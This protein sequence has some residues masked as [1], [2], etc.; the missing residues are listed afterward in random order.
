MPA[1]AVYILAVVGTIA[2][3][4]AFKEVNIN[5]ILSRSH[6]SY[7]AFQFVY[8]PHIAPKIEQWA[9]EF[10]ANRQARRRQ[11]SGAIA[12]PSPGRNRT[13]EDVSRSLEEERRSIEL[14]NLM[15]KEVREWR[16]EV[17]RS[18]LRLRNNTRNVLEEVRRFEISPQL[19]FI[20][21]QVY[22]RDSVCSDEPD[23]HRLR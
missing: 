8:E 20:H 6:D 4:V 21:F 14:E 12:V 1:P 15:A 7:L 18:N 10:L 13:D 3:G 5:L 11:R 17:D 9:E 23:S 19:M 16:S 2:A 22:A